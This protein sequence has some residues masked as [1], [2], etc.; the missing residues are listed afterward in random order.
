LLKVVCN[1]TPLIHL[2]KI[3][4]LNLL[5]DLFQDILVPNEV[6]IESI[7]SDSELPDAIEIERANW[8]HPL[9]IENTN[10]KRALMLML[11]EGESAA[12][13]LALEQSADLAIMDDYDARVVAKEYRLKVIGTIGILLRAKLTG[14]IPSLKHELDSLKDSGFWLSEELYQRAL[15]EAGE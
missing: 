9:K 2:A 1:S 15:K 3:G 13:V 14:K 11:D 6:L 12:I 8:I 4:R 10:L 7:G 5:K